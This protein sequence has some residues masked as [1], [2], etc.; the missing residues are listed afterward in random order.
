M[1]TDPPEEMSPIRALPFVVSQGADAG[2]A[3]LL[4]ILMTG[5]DL[6]PLSGAFVFGTLAP[7]IAIRLMR[8]DEAG[9]ARDMLADLAR[10]PVEAAVV[11]APRTGAPRVRSWCRRRPANPP[12]SQR[13]S[14]LHTRRS[15]GL[16]QALSC[17]C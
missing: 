4:A 5:S 8:D 17:S 11:R 1:R 7:A 14:H 6:A 3:G 15:V 12:A 13:R 16:R 10:G 2:V 9:Q